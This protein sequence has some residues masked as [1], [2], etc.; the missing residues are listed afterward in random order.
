M[1]QII[2]FGGIANSNAVGSVVAGLGAPSQLQGESDV[3]LS[4]FEDED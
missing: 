2:G 1:N 4:R 3:D